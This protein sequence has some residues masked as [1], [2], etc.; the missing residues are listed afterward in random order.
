MALLF[1]FLM[2]RRPPRSTLFPYTTL[3]RSSKSGLALT[4]ARSLASDNRISMRIQT[5]DFKGW[6]E[7]SGEVTWRSKSN[8]EAGVRFVGLA[9]DAEQQISDWTVSET[10]GGEFHSKEG[11]SDGIASQTAAA[12]EKIRNWIATE[13]R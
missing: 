10:L 1:F 4:T 12:N 2:I 3:F 8:K 13:A 7:A 5:P 11:A 9:E 6:I